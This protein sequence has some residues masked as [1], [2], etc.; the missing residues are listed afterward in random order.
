[1]A[2]KATKIPK[3]DFKGTKITLCLEGIQ[4][5]SCCCVAWLNHFS[6]EAPGSQ[7]FFERKGQRD[8]TGHGTSEGGRTA[9]TCTEGQPAIACVCGWHSP[10]SKRWSSQA[11]AVGSS[12]GHLVLLERLVGEGDTELVVE[13]PSISPYRREI[14]LDHSHKIG[15]SPKCVCSKTVFFLVSCFL[16]LIS[17]SCWPQWQK[18]AFSTA[19]ICM[20]RKRQSAS[21]PAHA[22]LPELWIN[23]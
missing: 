17:H 1:M 16:G 20:A 19:V 9:F 5:L 11:A 2:A 13:I 8:A 14:T 22:S 15:F 12:F 21:V 23:F 6:R 3:I 18:L 10:V 7:N 4:T